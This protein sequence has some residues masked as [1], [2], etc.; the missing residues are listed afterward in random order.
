M[1]INKDSVYYDDFGKC[2]CS[3]CVVDINVVDDKS[4]EIESEAEYINW[5]N[6]KDMWNEQWEYCK[7]LIK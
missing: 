2:Y 6:I 5:T 4:V 7:F 3:S 1:E